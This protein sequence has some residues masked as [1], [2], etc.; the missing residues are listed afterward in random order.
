MDKFKR[1]IYV[2]KN[3]TVFLIG[4]L[5]T[6][7]FFGSLLPMFLSTE[8]KKLISE[9]LFSF[10][11]QVKSGFDSLVLLNNGL[12]NNG[13]FLILIWLLGIS[14]IGVPIVLFLFFYKCFI[15]GFSISSIIYNFGFKGVLFSFAYIFPHH[16]IDLFIYGILTSFSLI[17]SIRLFFMFFKKVDFNIRESFN[18]YLKV[19]FFCCVVVVVSV[20]YEAFVNPYILSFIF[21]LLGL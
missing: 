14:V 8:D 12:F 17:F 7:I 9:Y 5:L 13:L 19:L 10:I 20:L 6:G 21:N 15:F 1:F 3:I 18:K 16:V 2:N 11:S 4:L